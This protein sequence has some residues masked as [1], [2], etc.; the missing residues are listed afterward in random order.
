MADLIFQKVKS[1]SLDLVFQAPDF[2]ELGV[3]DLEFGNTPTTGNDLMFGEPMPDP[4]GDFDLLFDN[5]PSEGFDL[6]F[7]SKDEAENVGFP[8]V[9]GELALKLNTPRLQTVANYIRYIYNSQLSLSLPRLDLDG[10]AVYDINTFQ[11]FSAFARQSFTDSELLFESK[12]SKPTEAKLIFN[13]FDVDFEEAREIT[14]E[15]VAAFQNTYTISSQT[16]TF[17]EAGQPVKTYNF[18]NFQS[19]ELVSIGN[20]QGFQR[21]VE[22]PLVKNYSLLQEA[23]PISVQFAVKA[24]LAVGMSVQLGFRTKLSEVINKSFDVN[25]QLAEY[26]V[27]VVKVI[28]PEPPVVDPP[29]N[30]Y[31]I[32]F[33]CL[34]DAEDLDSW[35]HNI[36]FNNCWG[37][38]PP[39]AVDYTE[40]FFVI[41]SISLINVETEEV[42]QATGID[43]ST[44]VSSYAWS[45]NFKISEA[46]VS[47]LSSPTNKPVMVALSFNGNLAVF[48]VQSISKTSTFNNYAYTVQII[49]PTALLDS[50][51]SRT[52]S[53]TVSEDAT[54]QALIEPML[55]TS[56]TGVS[57]NWEYLSALDW[58]VAANTYSYQELSP[59]KAIGKLLENSAAFMYS[60][61]DGTQLS[62]KRKRGSEFWEPAVGLIPL[63]P[64][65]ITALGFSRE[66]HRKFDAV[67]V[68]SG[69]NQTAGITA[70]VV[71]DAY[72]GTELAPQILAPTLTSPAAIRDAGKYRLGTAGVVE[73]RSLSQPII[74][75]FP[76]LIPADTV[77]FKAEGNT[78]IGTVISTSV[79]LKF[80]SQYQNFVVEVVKGF[81]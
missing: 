6:I 36:T 71:R 44:D 74:E 19:A 5:L 45:G 81:S 61:L 70:H 10:L 58:V 30:D 22:M 21:A 17:F 47:K 59:I 78:Y 57:L 42:I 12:T 1:D 51:Y 23:E 13:N 72:A 8:E 28:V 32:T 77:S 7:G 60:E 3:F 41:N 39:L 80:N 24:S 16:A 14:T 50:P 33:K 46:E 75:G 55:N 68:V 20:L 29:I 54:P 43:F 18:S 79:S 4:L 2:I 37:A 66:N 63:E 15:K 31:D 40:P 52:D 11:G 62:V 26:P 53:R 27:N 73:T 34:P 56:I 9:L 38:K 67:Y 64:H 76:L 48:M 25:Y 65:F 69:L 35:N 49:S